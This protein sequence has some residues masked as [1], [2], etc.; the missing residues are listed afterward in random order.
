[1]KVWGI[2]IC[3]SRA[4]GG[5]LLLYLAVR[6]YSPGSGKPFWFHLILGAFLLA[7]SIYSLFAVVR[8]SK[9]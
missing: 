2:I 5:V 1:M 3:L 6:F 8:Q 9:A 4:A 7:E